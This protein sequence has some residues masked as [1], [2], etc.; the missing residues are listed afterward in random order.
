MDFLK[1]EIETMIAFN[2]DLIIDCTKWDMKQ[3]KH[4][5]QHAKKHKTHITFKNLNLK[6]PQDAIALTYDPHGQLTIEI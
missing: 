1:E 6:K 3:L 5:V 4:F 2:C